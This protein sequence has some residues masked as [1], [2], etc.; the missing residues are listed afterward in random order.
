M[1]EKIYISGPI[2]G[3]KHGNRR[4]FIAAEK[5]LKKLDYKPIN[6]QR[7]VK[8]T[9][10]LPEFAYDYPALKKCLHLMLKTNKIYFLKNWKKSLGCRLEY[11]MAKELNYIIYY[12]EKKYGKQ[13]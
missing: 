9:D 3:I 5:K 11:T 12:E 2:T 8:S 7:L 6:P 10:G 1:K 4:E 13:L